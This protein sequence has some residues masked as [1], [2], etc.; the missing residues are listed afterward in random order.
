[1]AVTFGV[2]AL[3][4][5]PGFTYAPSIIEQRYLSHGGD[6]FAQVPAS[7]TSGTQVLRGMFN[8]VVYDYDAAVYGALYQGA[9]AGFRKSIYFNGIH[10]IAKGG[11]VYALL[12]D[13]SVLEFDKATGA[14]IKK[15][16]GAKYLWE[17][18]A[19]PP[20]NNGEI[21]LHRD[22]NQ[23]N[24]VGIYVFCDEGIFTVGG[25]ARA[26]SSVNRVGIDGAY[27]P[28]ARRFVDSFDPL[29][30]PSRSYYANADA[31]T[32][33]HGY[34]ITNAGTVADT[35][36]QYGFLFDGEDLYYRRNAFAGEVEPNIH[37]LQPPDPYPTRSAAIVLNYRD[38]LFFAFKSS[39]DSQKVGYSARFVR[40]G[41]NNFMTYNVNGDEILTV[42]A[43]TGLKM[44]ELFGGVI[45]QYSVPKTLIANDGTIVTM[46]NPTSTLIASTWTNGF[47]HGVIYKQSS[48]FWY[49]L[50]AAQNIRSAHPCRITTS[51]F[52]EF[53]CNPN[54]NE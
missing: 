22:A 33:V 16:V 24:G 32:I 34:G 20:Y 18:G 54:R 13:L 19:L 7:A 11:S 50:I 47:N 39:I 4:I 41:S 9:N 48:D 28:G 40:P 17:T 38:G 44:T 51:S 45:P 2:A 29:S 5:I 53:S 23:R 1:M 10:V 25:V 15:W 52:K 46:P 14:V 43:G 26:R 27:I 31:F 6:F 49:L 21:M 30:S 36:P 8:G 3:R 42:F 12:Y 37:A 35:W